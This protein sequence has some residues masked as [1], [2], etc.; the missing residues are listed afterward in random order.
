MTSAGETGGSG[1]GG[2]ELRQVDYERLA[3]LRYLLRRFLLF[4]EKAAQKAG[5]TAQQHQALLAVKG[6]R[7]PPLTIGAL[8]ERL[9]IQPHSAVGLLDRLEAKE[10][11][12]R[13]EA[14]ADRR[15]VLIG[16]TP[17]AETLLREL[18]V[19]HRAE[20]RRLAP[21]LRGLL[22]ALDDGE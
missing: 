7:G 11:I 13:S 2:A 22:S 6:H 5:L 10:L 16:L 21:L 15:Q 12:H 8:A 18:S 17:T 3:E 1:R 14:V 4:S 20:L 19:A 9:M